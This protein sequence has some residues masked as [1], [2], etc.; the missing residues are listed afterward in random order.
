MKRETHNQLIGI[1]HTAI[2]VSNE[3]AK[4][5]VKK[6]AYEDTLKELFEKQVLIVQQLKDILGY[7]GKKETKR[8]NE[9]ILET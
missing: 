7:N 8:D 2:E 5:S 6:V 4:R 3:L 1:L 9:D